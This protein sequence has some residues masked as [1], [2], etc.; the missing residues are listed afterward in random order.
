[1]HRIFDPVRA[2]RRVGKTRRPHGKASG[3]HRTT[4]AGER[5][6]IISTDR[7]RSSS[8]TNPSSK[9]V[10]GSESHTCLASRRLLRRR[11]Q[12]R[13]R[14]GS[15]T[16]PRTTPRGATLRVPH[17]GLDGS[18]ADDPPLPVPYSMPSN[19]AA[20]AVCSGS[21]ETA[22]SSP[23]S[24]SSPHRW[25]RLQRIHTESGQ[26]RSQGGDTGSDPVGAATHRRGQGR[27]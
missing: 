15:S 13:A 1:M 19:R 27:C 17:R 2:S 3:A 9:S 26:S 20:T 8:T 10:E 11:P 24:L 18:A 4:S 12:R 22:G 14:V 16:C 21:A 23:S 6:F 5:C 7:S 25:E